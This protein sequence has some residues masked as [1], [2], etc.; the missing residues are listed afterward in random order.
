[1]I[2]SQPELPVVG[3]LL[4]NTMA[5]VLAV[6]Y[7]N[8]QAQTAELHLIDLLMTADK[9]TMVKACKDR[10]IS[11]VVSKPQIDKLQID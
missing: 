8:S 1:M 4:E 7:S 9:A 2:N 3:G 6:L 5:Q 11:C 10:I